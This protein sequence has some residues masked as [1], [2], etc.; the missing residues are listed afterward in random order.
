MS[1]PD[2]VP[3]QRQVQWHS[4]VFLVGISRSG[5]SG[6]GLT[7][8]CTQYKNLL[9]ATEWRVLNEKTHDLENPLKFWM[10]CRVK[11]ELGELYTLAR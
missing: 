11:M 2:P 8:G 1:R 4:Q 5:R 6:D 7:F 9:W 10:M 3:G